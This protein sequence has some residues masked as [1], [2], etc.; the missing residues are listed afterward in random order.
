MIVSFIATDIISTLFAVIIVWIAR[1]LD[2]VFEDQMSYLVRVNNEE[3]D[4]GG[5]E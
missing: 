3:K 4:K 2:G 5:R 1:K